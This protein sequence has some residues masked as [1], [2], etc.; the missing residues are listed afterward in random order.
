MTTQRNKNKTWSDAKQQ[1]TTSETRNDFKMTSKGC[2]T[3]TKGFL[4]TSKGCKMDT[5]RQNNFKENLY[6]YRETRINYKEKQTDTET[7]NDLEGLHRGTK[8]PQ[9][10]T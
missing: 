7:Q 6:N 8:Q 10:Y 4:T 3:T 9:R 1:G 2:K 5:K